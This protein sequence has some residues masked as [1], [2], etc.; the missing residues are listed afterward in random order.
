LKLVRVHKGVKTLSLTRTWNEGMMQMGGDKNFACE[1]DRTR[2]GSRGGLA[3]GV[4]R[5]LGSMEAKLKKT[6]SD[7]L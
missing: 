3:H 2:K 5:A 7:N 6:A 1:P 4:K